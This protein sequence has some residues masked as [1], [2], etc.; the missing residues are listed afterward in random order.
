[1]TPTDHPDLERAQA[2]TLRVLVL[3]QAIGAVGITIGIATASL[4][5]RD[6]S[7][8]DSLAGLAQTFQVLGAAVASYLLAR[9]MSRRG[10][11]VGLVAG[12]LLGA[13]GA[14]TAVLAGVV[15][16]MLVLLLG[17]VLLGSAT[18]ANSGSRYAA[19]DLAPTARRGRSLSIVVWAT[20]IG[21]VAGP[22]LTGPAASLARTLGLPALTGPFL[23]GTAGMLGAAL[24]VGLG[25]RPDPLLLARDVAG[26]VPGEPDGTSW[27]RAREAVRSEP[28][29]GWAVTGL[30]GAHA[31]MVAVMV[32]TPLHM[33]HGGAALRVIGVVI[34]VHV[35]GMFAF[36]PVVGLLADRVGRERVLGAG[37][38]TL[39]ASL[40]LAALSPE[41]S[42]VQIFGGLFLLG[43]GWSLATVSASTMVADLAPL[44]ARTDV[45]G[46]ADLV[47]NL[48]AA[49]AGG[50]AGVVVGV[51]GYPVL[52]LVT[53]ALAGVVVL[54]AVRAHT[55]ARTA[56]PEPGLA[57]LRR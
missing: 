19:T 50:L 1:M 38:V 7:G 37:G 28:A 23:I 34:S 33:E 49:V 24:V 10:R 52:A 40:G 17:A 6:L 30:A 18:A 11:R 41:G 16:S 39:A 3:A 51:A 4:L 15:G 53:L 27:S 29:L 2:R 45:Q 22:N 20:T 9:L 14:A 57:E 54:A 32:M 44:E 42:S 13:A 36:S 55:L 12:W 8:R 48:S 35:L 56:E 5:A 43:L 46:A 21:A 25:L 47:M 31:A 26:V